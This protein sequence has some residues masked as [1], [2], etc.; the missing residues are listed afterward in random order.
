MSVQIGG[1]ISSNIYRADDAPFYKRGNKV[2]IGICVLD[3]FLFLG[4]KLYYIQ[5]NK[6]KTKFWELYS[7][8]EKE[9]YLATT[10]DQG[11]KRLD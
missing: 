11:N 9:H 10:K 3:I 4:V 6:Y 2:L 7:V 5:R 1:I 8:E